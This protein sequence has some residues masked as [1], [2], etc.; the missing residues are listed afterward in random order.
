MNKQSIFK[1]IIT[2]AAFMLYLASL[3]S[4]R[5]EQTGAK[6]YKL[7]SPNGKI[8]LTVSLNNDIQYSVSHDGDIMLNPSAISMTLGDGKSFGKK[9]T[10]K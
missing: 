3:H 7:S 8:T 5:A 2:G 4:L 1:V 9:S 6:N 10:L